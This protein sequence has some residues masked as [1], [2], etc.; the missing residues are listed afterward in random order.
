MRTMNLRLAILPV[1]LAVAACDGSTTQ[2]TPETDAARD[3]AGDRTLAQELGTDDSR[4]AAAVKAAGLEATLS[5]PGPYTVLVPSNAAFDKLPAGTMDNL[6]KPESKAALT[7]LLS[8]HILSGAVL[9]QDVARAVETGKG[10]TQLMTVGGGVLT[11]TKEGDAIVLT[12]GAG[13]KS[14]LTAP[15]KKVSNGVV[16]RVDAVLMPK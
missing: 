13:A 1:A 6:L 9:T 7:A 3:A 11:V 10:K 14:T 2:A 4:F 15:D 5:G 16:H 12:D 8:N